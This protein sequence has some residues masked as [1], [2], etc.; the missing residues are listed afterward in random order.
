MFSLTVDQELE[1]RLFQLHQAEELFH[2]VE[3]NRHH[4]LT[5]LPWVDGMTSPLHSRSMILMWL[6]QFEEN[7][8]FNAGIYFRGKLVGGIGFHHT[9]WFNSQ[10][11]IGYFLVKNAEGNGI[12]TR[13]VRALVQFAFQELHLNRI[14]IRCGEKNIRSRAVPERLGFT[15][16]GLIRQGERLNGGF[17]NLFVYSLL[18][19]EWHELRGYSNELNYYGKNLK[20]GKSNN[21]L[22]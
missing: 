5:W 8:G 20:K 10:T 12:I 21:R 22:F 4:L 19:E 11:S 14:E 9:D 1:L 15:K 16:E 3:Q 17:H 13:C 2:L 7:S 18:A 6:R